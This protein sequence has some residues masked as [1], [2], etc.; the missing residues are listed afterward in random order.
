[1]SVVSNSISTMLVIIP[2]DGDVTAKHTS[3]A[4]RHAVNTCNVILS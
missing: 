3:V 4:C 1:M 2:I